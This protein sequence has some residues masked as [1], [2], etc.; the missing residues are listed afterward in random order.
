MGIPGEDARDESTAEA[1]KIHILGREQTSPCLSG[2]VNALSS[3]IHETNGI[4]S[5]TK[6]LK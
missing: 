1:M 6:R 5:H 3:D 2:S 4:P